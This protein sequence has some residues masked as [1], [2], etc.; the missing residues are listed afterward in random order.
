M[1]LTH[2]DFNGFGLAQ[3]LIDG[4]NKSGFNT[5]TPIQAQAI[6][7]AMEGRDVLGLAQTGTG[8]TA[9]FGLP[10]LHHLLQMNTRPSPKTCRALI[11]APTRELAVQIQETLRALAGGARLTMLLVLGGTS[12][13]AQVRTLARGVDILVA[14][15]GRL[16]DLMDDGHVRFDETSIFV[17]DEADRMLDMGFI[18]PVQ[19]IARKLHPRRRTA[20]F[21][22][23]MPK[24]V[25]GLAA[26]LLNDPIRVEV[27]PPG[28]TI[29]KINQSVELM[30]HGEKRA[31]LAQIVTG[32]DAGRVIVFARTKRGADRVAENLIKDGIQADAIHGN[33]A[34]NARQRALK[35]FADGRVRVL[36]ATDIAARG[37]DVKDITHV[38]QYDLP[39][40][41]EAYVHRIGRTGRNG[42]EGTAIAFCSPD[43]RDKLKSVEKLTR[44][45]L[46]PEGAEPAP[47]KA[48]GPSRPPRKP[49]GTHVSPR[50]AQGANRAKQD[51]GSAPPRRRRP[52]RPAKA[53]ASA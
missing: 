43:E 30:P 15:P 48:K 41:P 49:Q 11:L 44:L 14:T 16:T 32:P 12:R 3:P 24:E 7:P 5:P 28:K 31:R 4:L 42:A 29:V 35:A 20:L 39:D 52:R 9:A 2:T 37:I 26:G 34:Q 53:H 17:L 23:T 45:S 36:V 8:K 19:T 22:A 51:P 1:N 6:G 10:M 27:A 47:R 33:K 21:S 25:E 38:V 13:S 50:G 18:K 46:T 40:E